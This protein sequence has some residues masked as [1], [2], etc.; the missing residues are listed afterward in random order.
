MKKKK[1]KIYDRR[2]LMKIY[3]I[4]TN[5]KKKSRDKTSN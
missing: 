5:A 2:E 1:L 4:N 3:N